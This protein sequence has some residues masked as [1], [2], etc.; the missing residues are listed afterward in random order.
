MV[1]PTTSDIYWKHGF[2]CVIPH[3]RMRDHHPIDE[4]MTMNLDIFQKEDNLVICKVLMYIKAR[5]ITY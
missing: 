3:F 4:R 5:L 1:K 2:L